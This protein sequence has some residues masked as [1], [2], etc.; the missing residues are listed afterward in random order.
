MVWKFQIKQKIKRDCDGMWQK[1]TI[2]PMDYSVLLEGDCAGACPAHWQP[3]LTGV[4]CVVSARKS[5]PFFQ[6]L[7]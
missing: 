5:G 6:S 4:G 7:Q 2:A 1:A 3:P